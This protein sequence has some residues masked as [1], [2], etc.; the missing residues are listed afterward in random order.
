MKSRVF[1]RERIT[2]CI[3]AYRGFCGFVIAISQINFYLQFK[4]ISLIKEMF[5]HAFN[6]QSIFHERIRTFCNKKTLPT[7]RNRF[8][9]CMYLYL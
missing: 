4:S 8:C 9:E 7:S 6:E 1:H 3:Y 2:S 5:K